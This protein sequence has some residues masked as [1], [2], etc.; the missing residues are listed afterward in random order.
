MTSKKNNIH[1]GCSGYYYSNWKN[2][3]YPAGLPSAKW[4]EYY[5]SVFNTVE[6]NSTFYRKPQVS[7][8]K[9]YAA[10]TPDKFTF[11]VKMSRYITHILRLKNAATHIGE[12][13]ELIYSGL[14]N[15][16]AAFL[17]QFPGTFRCTEEN[18]ELIAS[19]IPEGKHNVVE[20]RHISWWSEEVRNLLVKKKITFCNVDYP[21]LD[22]YY[23]NTTDVFYVR[24]HGNPELFKTRYT[25]PQLR[26]FAKSFP[27]DAKQY[28]IY[29]NNTYYDGGY[30]NAQEMMNVLNQ[31]RISAHA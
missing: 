29:F 10:A 25:V 28:F 20:F 23:M 1:I 14:G 26:K 2:A 12:F 31:K 3:F 22:S 16:V 4:L 8:L 27:A 13:Q 21:G 17:F 11:A 7:A 15:K 24:F 18:L 5:G 6:L 30:S 19:V 9:R